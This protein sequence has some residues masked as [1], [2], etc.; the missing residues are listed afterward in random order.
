MCVSHV[1]GDLLGIEILRTYFFVLV[2][3]GWCC[4]LLLC[5]TK[6]PDEH[7]GGMF[8]RHDAIRPIKV[9]YPSWPVVRAFVPILARL[10]L[11]RRDRRGF[12]RKTVFSQVGLVA[13]VVGG[14][15]YFASAEF[16]F[17]RSR[18]MGTHFSVEGGGRI[19][20]CRCVEYAK[21]VLESNRYFCRLW[22]HL[23][24]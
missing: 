5:R 22:L 1:H 21:N 14:V 9:L 23:P 8:T 24:L 20:T 2:V 10:G 11:T 16:P 17:G 12:P 7:M 6:Y 13:A 15:I 18:R 19:S 3:C 4:S